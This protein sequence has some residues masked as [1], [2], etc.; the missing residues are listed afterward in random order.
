MR[1]RKANY[2]CYL[3]VGVKVYWGCIPQETRVQQGSSFPT[4]CFSSY[5]EASSHDSRASDMCSQTQAPRSICHFCFWRFMGALDRWSCSWNRLQAPKIG[6][7]SKLPLLGCGCECV[8]IWRWQLGLNKK[9]NKKGEERKRKL[10]W[11]SLI[12]CCDYG[13]LGVAC[14]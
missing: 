5:I 3:S 12:S 9:I 1:V 10:N 14:C 4:V 11:I 13:Q 6:K 7:D 8:I 2:C